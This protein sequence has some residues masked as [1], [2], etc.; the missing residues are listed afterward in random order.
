LTVDCRF[1][2]L[3]PSSS[4]SAISINLRRRSELVED[5]VDPDAAWREQAADSFVSLSSFGVAI[6]KAVSNGDSWSQKE[7]KCTETRATGTET[8][9]L[10]ETYIW[11]GAVISQ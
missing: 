10:A 4:S 1:L 3:S 8:G 6:E 11:P 9:Q 7:L 5:D 2:S